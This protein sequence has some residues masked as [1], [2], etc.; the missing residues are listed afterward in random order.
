MKRPTDLKCGCGAA[1]PVGRRGPLPDLP[2]ARCRRAASA[3][4]AVRL[5]KCIDCGGLY[6]AGGRGPSGRCPSCTRWHCL[7]V[8]NVGSSGYHPPRGAALRNLNRSCVSCGVVLPVEPKWRGRLC[9]DCRAHGSWK[10]CAECSTQIRGGWTL[11]FCPTCS[12]RRDRFRQ[13]NDPR[14]QERVARRNQL[15]SDS[16]REIRE[17]VQHLKRTTRRC[18]LCDVELTREPFLRNSAE[19]DHILPIVAGGDESIVNLRVICRGC[20]TSRPHDG[21]QRSWERV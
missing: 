10:S 15:V 13:R 19:K 20:N 6:K 7:L 14:R 12:T 2:C 16:P 4:R 17:Y 3:F 8:L 9:A 21:F 18:P 11:T 1:V 5:V